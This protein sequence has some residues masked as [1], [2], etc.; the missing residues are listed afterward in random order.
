MKHRNSF[1]KY[2]RSGFSLIELLVVVA[3]GLIVATT[4][5]P[6]ITA[7]IANVRM[8]ASISSLSGMLQ[9]TRMLAVKE[10]KIKTARFTVERGGLIVFAKDASSTSTDVITSDP[11]VQ[12][13]APITKLTTPSGAGAPDALTA[14]FLGFTPS[15]S[16]PSF[17][18]RG[19]PCL[20]A[21]GA[22]PN[23]GFAYYF[24]DTR[25]AGSQGWS[26]ITISPA[27]RITKW[28]WNGASWGN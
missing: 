25:R 15:P 14:T 10:N 23:R 5:V 27:G 21:G 2:P 17:N 18:S 9:S 4:A 28:F 6:A 22:C 8:R 12:L 24:K 7:T 11:Q 3:I 16:I 19:L 26:A 13:E 1:I 20:Y